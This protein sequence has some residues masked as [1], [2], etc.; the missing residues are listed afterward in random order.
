VAHESAEAMKGGNRWRKGGWAKK[1]ASPESVDGKGGVGF[2]SGRDKRKRFAKRGEEV[3]SKSTGEGKRECGGGGKR[4]GQKKGPM[5]RKNKPEPLAGG[6]QASAK[7]KKRK[8]GPKGVGSWGGVS[9]GGGKKFVGGK[10][11]CAL[12]EDRMS[13]GERSEEIDL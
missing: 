1:R 13:S 9:K 2:G 6:V 11:G 10:K 12:H 4:P 3:E 7:Q 5:S 8:G